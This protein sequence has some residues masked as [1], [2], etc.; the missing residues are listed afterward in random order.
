MDQIRIETIRLG[1]LKLKLEFE[2]Q[3]IGSREG[4]E[5]VK[6]ADPL[7]RAM[8]QSRRDSAA[9]EV[10]RIEGRLIDVRLAL[11]A[12]EDG[13]YGICA[14]CESNIAPRRLEAAP[15]ATLCVGCQEHK[16]R[17]EG[18]EGQKPKGK[19]VDHGRSIEQE[20]KNRVRSQEQASF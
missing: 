14:R 12:L 3:S 2:S 19:L 17:V 20:A 8:E 10:N 18:M 4:L 11:Q 16:E 13:E 6:T 15:W 1:L 5:I 9:S 7:D